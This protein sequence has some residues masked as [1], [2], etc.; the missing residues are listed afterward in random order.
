MEHNGLGGDVVVSKAAEQMMGNVR[1]AAALQTDDLV[2][3]IATFVSLIG[4]LLQI[5]DAETLAQEFY[6][7]KDWSTL[8]RLTDAVSASP[9][10]TVQIQRLLLQGLMESGA[11]HAAA[12]VAGDLL[13][14][15]G[16]DDKEHSELLGLIG[17]VKKDA[18]LE[19]GSPEALDASFDAYR[20]GYEFGYDRLWHGVNIVALRHRSEL[21]EPAEPTADELLAMARAPDERDVWSW[22]TEVELI[23]GAGAEGGDASEAIATLLAHDGFTPQVLGSLQRQ[24]ADLY[25]MA[26]DAPAM[27][28]LSEGTLQMLGDGRIDPAEGIAVTLP[29][30]TGEYEKIFGDEQPVPLKIYAAGAERARSVAKVSYG[31]AG[32]GT[33]FVIAGDD[34]HPSL[35]GRLALVTN[36]HVV[37]KPGQPDPR[38][39]HVSEVRLEFEVGPDGEP[40]TLHDLRAVWFSMKEELDVCVM[41]C[42]EPAMETLRPL[43]VARRVPMPTPDAYVYVIGHPGGAELKFSIRGNDF[44]DT[45]FVRLHYT[46]PTEKGSSGSPVFDLEWN[47]IGVHHMGL[48]EM[49]RIQG[50]GT[51]EA[52]EGMTIEAIRKRMA[53]DPPVPEGIG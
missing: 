39:K 36:E 32:I 29:A 28:Q 15:D 3:E 52:N 12:R 23:A 50:E 13:E 48:S 51:Y 4:G 35:A 53:D 22:A 19:T 16:L 33:A 30:S 45:D 43:G 21:G 1:T 10:A 38:G 14:V 42:D 44:V 40:V 20:R 6:D 8:V 27:L 41:L 26:A 9:H 37:A 18:Y 24:L 34:L 2:V 11:K 47:L 31:G 46:A 5:E 17:R 25:G 7:A 49:S